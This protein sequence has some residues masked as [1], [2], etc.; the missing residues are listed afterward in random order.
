MR[1]KVTSKKVLTL[2]DIIEI[3]RKRLK[4]MVKGDD[5]WWLDKSRSDWARREFG[6]T[7]DGEINNETLRLQMETCQLCGKDFL[8]DEKFLRLEFSFCDEYDCVMNICLKCL[9]NLV[10]LAKLRVI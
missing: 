9:R 7:L 6:D 4:A 2:R 5:G 1:G 10:K 3:E 8:L